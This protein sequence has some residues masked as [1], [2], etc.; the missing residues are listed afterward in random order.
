L[1]RFPK[2]FLFLIFVSCHDNIEPMKKLRWPLLIAIVALAAIS[3][4]LLN[5]KPASLQPI[6]APVVQPAV[7]GIYAEGL[8]GTFMRLN[9]VLDYYNEADRDVDRLLFS[10]MLRIDDRGIPQADLATS[11]GISRDGTIYNF[12][13]NPKAVWH[14]GKPVTS[15]D[16]IFTI[17]MMSADDSPLPADQ[18]E[19]WKQ[20]EITR[21]D[22][23][24]IQFKLPEPFA[25]F[26][27]YLTFGVLPSHLVGDLTLTDLINDPFNLSPIGS[28]PY[29]FDHLITHEGQISGVVLSAFKDYYAQ[30]AYID[31]I[32]LHYYPDAASA[33]AAYQSGDIAGIGNVTSDILPKVM[34]EKGLNLYTTR[35]PSMTLILLNLDDPQVKFF[36][37]VNIRKALMQGLNRQAMIDKLRS[38]QAILADDPIF[39][40][41][42]AYYGGIEKYTYRPN[43][44]IDQLRGAGFTIPASG[45]NIRASED[46]TQ[47]AFELLYPDDPEHAALAQSIQDDW[48]ILGAQV[49][50]TPLPYDQLV[51]ERLDTRT[52]QAA[53]VDLNLSR[54]SDPDPYPFWH[55]T[56]ITSGQNYSKW[57][58]RQ[59]SEYLEQAR[60]TTDLAERTKLYNNF[61]VRWSE[62]LPA[63]PLYYPVYTYAVS[64]D[65]QGVSIGPV[66]DPADRFNH[67]TSWYLVT[68][69]PTGEETPTPTP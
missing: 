9:P 62:E 20:I 8:V 27:S 65:V 32:A 44:A 37:D 64:S 57:D 12:S 63:L 60:I 15:D 21:L 48:S 42:W 24:T 26:L 17:Q 5:Q 43:Q 40:G 68:S 29:H 30:P 35:L 46:G 6:S 36:Q 47:L 18:R 31:Q 23:K 4:L 3:I 55:Q 52:Y 39:P 1:E 7:G 50:L 49:K 38:G 13:L 53:L 14:D 34:S 16:V 33:Y 56:Q 41:T 10:G 45:G 67:V 11:W 51:S 25:P 22:D 69:H 61:Q 59:A 66:F 58:D 54:S 19:F 28:G 2:R